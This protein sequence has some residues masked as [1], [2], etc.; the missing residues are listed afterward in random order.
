MKSESVFYLNIDKVYHELLQKSNAGKTKVM[1]AGWDAVEF[2]ELLRR[3]RELIN[4]VE[5]NGVN[6]NLAAFKIK[7]K[8]YLIGLFLRKRVQAKYLLVFMI[9]DELRKKKPYAVPFSSCRIRL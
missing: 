9:A 1:E 6:L 5:G 2:Q 8:S 4:D 7:V 3:A